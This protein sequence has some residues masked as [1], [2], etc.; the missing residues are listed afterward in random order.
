M[1]M[2]RG[3]VH[4]TAREGAVSVRD[5][6]GNP[7]DDKTYQDDK[8]KRHQQELDTRGKTGVQP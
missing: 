6:A 3:R 1:P 5:K 4:S 2:K 7:L 8:R